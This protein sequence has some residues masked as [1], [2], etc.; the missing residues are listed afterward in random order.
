M[1]RVKTGSGPLDEALGGGLPPGQT[2][3]VEGPQGVGSTEF[4]FA[5]LRAAAADRTGKAIFAS[6]MRTPARAQTEA[7]ELLGA[8][9]TQPITFA[10]I[11]PTRATLDCLELV[12]GLGKGD[13]LVIE[14]AAALARASDVPDPV[15]LVQR[16]GD[17][18]H[19]HGAA[20]L[21]LHSPGT[22]PPLVEAGLQEAADGIFTFGWCDGG[23]TRR[24]SLFITKLRGLAPALDGEQVP[25]FDASLQN[26][27]GFAVSRVK[28]V[29]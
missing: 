5:V 13:V 27:L 6:A 1:S 28:S 18:A 8:H 15:G 9:A 12:E 29:V 4:A 19:A 23:P 26:G 24:R 7:R 10:A 3:L 25:V 2:L 22:L 14:S 11:R 16:L 17:P 20:L 21:L